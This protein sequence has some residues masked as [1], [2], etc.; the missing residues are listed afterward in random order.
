MQTE[1]PYAAPVEASPVVERALA[2][3]ELSI[4][5]QNRRFVNFLIDG[6]VSQ[7]VSGVA[8]FGLGII[9]ALLRVSGGHP[10]GPEDEATL[11]L[12]GWIVGMLTVCGYYILTEAVWQRSIDKLVTG[13]RVV[14]ADGRRPTLKQVVGRTA[15]RFIPFE[16]FSFLG[17]KGYPIGWH[18]RL[19]GT[20]VI[21]TRG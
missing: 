6:L 3:T 19:S 13:T 17:G 20:R 10:I 1:N 5:S 9:Y 21:R 8:G 4:A 18:D 2:T 14:T 12:L 15:A 7:L 16:A 11:S